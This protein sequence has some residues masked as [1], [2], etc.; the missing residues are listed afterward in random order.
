MDKHGEGPQF[1]GQERLQV[2]YYGRVQGVG[3]RAQVADLATS[4]P[5]EGF[6]R[7]RIDGS[8][9]LVCSGKTADLI[10]FQEAI[11]RRLSRNIVSEQEEWTPA[12]PGEFR[13]FRITET[14]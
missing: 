2:F 13:G 12:V 5:I 7:N 8:V 3:F 14:L 1:E 6:V 9:E 10:A 4:S 11:R